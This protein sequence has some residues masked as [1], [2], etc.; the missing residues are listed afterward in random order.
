MATVGE[1]TFTCFVI[2]SDKDITALTTKIDRV[3]L[4]AIDSLVSMNTRNKLLQTGFIADQ[5]NIKNAGH[6]IKSY[7]KTCKAYVLHGLWFTLLL[8]NEFK[9]VI[10]VTVTVRFKST[11]ALT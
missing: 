5:I 1:T 7:V 2:Y 11:A 4:T 6:V 8:L 9:K 3:T 10:V